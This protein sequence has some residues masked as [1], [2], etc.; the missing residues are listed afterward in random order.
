MPFGQGK[1]FLSHNKAL[2]H[3]VGGWAVNVNSTMQTGFPLAIYESSNLNSAIGA[4][5]FRPNATGVSPAT[6]GSLEQRIGGY[7]NSAAFSYSRSVHI[8]ERFAHH[9]Q[10]WPGHGEH[11]CVALRRTTIKEHYNGQFRIESFNV[12][13][14]PYFYAPGAD[15]SNSGNQ[16]GSSS[17]GLVSLSR[18]TSR[19]SSRWVSA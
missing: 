2:G 7:L 11:G 14:T 17:F 12:T 3:V 6:T 10:P 16:V 1:P 8:W 15:G 9:P 13:N 18:R 5:V 4:S 19:A